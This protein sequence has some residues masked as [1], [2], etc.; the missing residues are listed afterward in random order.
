[1][2]S[3]KNKINVFINFFLQ[4]LNLN[5]VSLSFCVR[6][7]MVANNNPVSGWNPVKKPQNAFLKT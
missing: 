5:K 6:G 2:K 7:L 1:M 3:K 4:D